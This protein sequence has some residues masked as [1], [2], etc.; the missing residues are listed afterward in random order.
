MAE[1]IHQYLARIGSQGGKKSRRV[2]SPCAARNM[3]KIREAKRAY[4]KFHTQC[5]WS[6][7]LDYP[8]GISDLPWIATQL[9]TYGGRQGWQIG[10]KLC[11]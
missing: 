1:S 2:L 7:A 5:F 10:N 3:V 4:R 8:I 6:F 9:K 11:P